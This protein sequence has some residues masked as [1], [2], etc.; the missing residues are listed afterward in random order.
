MSSIPFKD[1][2]LLAVIGDEDSVTGLLLAGIGHV[3]HGKK[4][5]LVVD[6][7]TP[8]PIIEAAFEEYTTR[9]DIAILLINQHVAEKI[10]PTVD[11]YQQAFPAL[12]EIPSKDHPYDPSK[13]SILKRVQ[14]LFGD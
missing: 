12:L 10:R 9:K 1:R 8:I 13:D 3:E 6:S 5:F 14:K 11:K 2:N 4:N 7:K